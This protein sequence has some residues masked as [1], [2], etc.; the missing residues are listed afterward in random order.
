M[1]TPGSH[2][3]ERNLARWNKSR[4]DGYGSAVSVGVLAG[5]A[6]TFARTPI[7]MPGHKAIWWITPILASR[8]MTRPRAGASVAAVT[9]AIT[10]LTLGGRL[11]GGFAS[12]P[13][14]ILAGA[15]LDLAARIA[16]RREFSISRRLLFFAL[17]GAA[18]N[19][20][21]FAQRFA[22][23]KTAI[24]AT[25]N[26]ADLFNAACSHGAFGFLAGLLGAAAGAA[27]LKW[28][29]ETAHAR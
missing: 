7:H 10:T 22:D 3:I 1:N 29:A 4:T 8:L 12:L 16:E 27:L 14:I 21:C 24:F 5:I 20:L 26:L 23:P 13:L 2:S 17:A 18:A 9:A 15:L 6:V 19:L 11:G 25:G 28:R